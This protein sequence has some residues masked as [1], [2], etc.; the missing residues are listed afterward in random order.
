MRH[1]DRRR[2]RESLPGATEILRPQRK[3][4]GRAQRNGRD[5]VGPAAGVEKDFTARVFEVEPGDHATLEDCVVEEPSFATDPDERDLRPAI[6]GETEAE[7]ADRGGI[8]DLQAQPLPREDIERRG[9]GC[10]RSRRGGVPA[11]SAD[12]LAVGEDG[13]S[14]VDPGGRARRLDVGNVPRRERA[15]GTPIFVDRGRLAEVHRIG[16]RLWPPGVGERHVWLRRAV[17][18]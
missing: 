7:K 15:P 18:G 11:A 10:E 17:V 12:V 16:R 8:G 3:N 2:E 6:V 5:D 4:A 1:G 14:F 13:L 9:I